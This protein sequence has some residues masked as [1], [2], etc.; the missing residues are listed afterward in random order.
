[1]KS[2]SSFASFA[3]VTQASSIV[4]PIFTTTDPSACL[5]SF[6]VSISITLPSDNS[7]FLLIMF[8][9]LV[10][11]CLPLWEL[12]NIIVFFLCTIPKYILCSCACRRLNGLLTGTLTVLLNPSG[13]A[14][15]RRLFKKKRPAATTDT[16]ASFHS[17]IGMG[18][19]PS[20]YL[21]YRRRPSSLT[22]F[23]Y[24]SM[25]FSLR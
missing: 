8:M 23:L 20:R 16:L 24:L 11:T 14:G 6:P 4:P 3:Q 12:I 10:S 15:S 21:D 2:T 1:M 9:N 7:I 5:A 13:H 25:S 17:H 22:M 18:P 19:G